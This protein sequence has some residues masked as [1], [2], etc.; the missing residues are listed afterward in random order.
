MV[1][2]KTEIF[3]DLINIT[4]IL[5]IKTKILTNQLKY[6]LYKINGIFGNFSLL[7]VTLNKG[8]SISNQS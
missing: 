6:F 3:K 1:A 7:F 8:E 2:I 5:P 4:I